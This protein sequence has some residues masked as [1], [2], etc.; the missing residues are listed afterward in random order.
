MRKFLFFALALLALASCKDKTNT[1]ETADL[2]QRIDSL[3]RVNVQKDNE[4]NDMLE[5]LNTIEDGF[6]AI[7]EAQGRVTVERRGEGADA[8][9]RIRENMQFINETMTQNKDL[10]N[11]LRLRLR[12]SNTASEQLRK[13]LENLTAQLEAK[14]SELAVLRQELEAKD[15]HIAELDEQVSQL[16]EDVTTLKDD[17]ARKEET[18]SQQDKELNTAWYVFGTKRELKEQ[19]ILKSGEVLQGNFNKNYFTKIDIRVDK[20]IKLMSRDAKLLTNHPAGSYTLERD[21]NKQYVLRITN[22]QQF[23]STSKYLVV[24]VK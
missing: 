7:N 14:E 6:R 1:R 24:Q 21:A 4:I 12:D 11:K 9:Q 2:N 3:N 22:P 23:W 18:I 10:I 16:N 5:T 17:K 13:T 19:N 8:A 15:I 20:E